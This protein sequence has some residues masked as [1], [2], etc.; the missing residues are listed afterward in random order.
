MEDFF[1]YGIVY[2]LFVLFTIGGL[3]SKCGGLKESEHHLVPRSRCPSPRLRNADRNKKRFPHPQHVAFHDLFANMVQVEMMHHLNVYW[4][5]RTGVMFN[6]I[7]VVARFGDVYKYSFR[8]NGRLYL[9]TYGKHHQDIKYRE[10]DWDLV[11]GRHVDAFDAMVQIVKVWS[12]RG[13]Y[14][15]KVVIR[16][17]NDKESLKYT[18]YPCRRR[19]RKR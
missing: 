19:R 11:F 18:Y 14:W 5:E 6:R 17:E 10:R 4:A 12:P 3:V 16:A 7:D 1:Q 8:K 9:Q 13:D 2:I 15:Q